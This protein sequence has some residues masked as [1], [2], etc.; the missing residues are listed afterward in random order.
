MVQIIL[1]FIAKAVYLNLQSFNCRG[2][3]SEVSFSRPRTLNAAQLPIL[4]NRQCASS[5]GKDF[6]PIQSFCAGYMDGTA[7]SCQGDSGGPF[8]VDGI[9]WGV[10]SWGEG[11]AR[12]GYPGI[13]TN[14]A[15]Y[16]NWIDSILNQHN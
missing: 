13:Y 7:D 6:I 4:E 1:V 15:N 9:L 2:R 12:K 16:R 11:C 5:Y 3:Q 10:V 8:V 14:V